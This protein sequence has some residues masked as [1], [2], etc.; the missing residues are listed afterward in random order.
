MP[1]PAYTIDGVLPPYVGPAGPG[2]AA[3]DMSP[4]VMTA[5]EVAAT[6]ATTDERKAI[7][8]GWLRHRAALRAVGFDR[9]FQWLDGSFVENKN[10]RDLDVVTFLYRP[11]GHGGGDL[12]KLLRANLRG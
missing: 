4:Y 8:R 1:I 12:A 6:F 7:L 3:E 11:P 2:G 5:I 10:P 9:G